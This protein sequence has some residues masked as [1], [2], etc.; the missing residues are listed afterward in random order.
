MQTLCQINS[1]KMWLIYFAVLSV[2]PSRLES[3]CMFTLCVC[4]SAGEDRPQRFQTGLRCPLRRLEFGNHTGED[5]DL[6]CDRLCVR[7]WKW[8]L[9]HCCFSMNWPR[10]GSPTRSGTVC[11]ISWRRWWRATRHSSAALRRDSSPPNSSTSST[12]G[13]THTHTWPRSHCDLQRFLFLRV[14]WLSRGDVI[15]QI[16][17]VITWCTRRLLLLI[18]SNCKSSRWSLWLTWFWRVLIK[19]FILLFL[20]A[21]QRTIQKGQS[22]KS[23]WWVPVSCWKPHVQHFLTWKLN[24]NYYCYRK[25]GYIREF[26]IF[27]LSYHG[28]GN[29]AIKY[30]IG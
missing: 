6:S 2:L 26:F 20:T 11:S 3:F 18:H 14:C 19:S 24:E 17:C 15:T 16:H 29:Y 21:L 10:D 30:L 25:H 13:E 28:L 5:D 22:T 1:C 12:C 7:Y 9:L 4:P 23:F 27:I 8:F